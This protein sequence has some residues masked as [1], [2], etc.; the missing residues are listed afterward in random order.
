MFLYILG[1]KG[2]NFWGNKIA[3]GDKGDLSFFWDCW[4]YIIMSGFGKQPAKKAEKPIFWGGYMLSAKA[5][6]TKQYPPCQITE[7]KEQVK[8][9]ALI[10][11]LNRL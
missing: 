11:S 10:S 3:E 1:V 2:T 9:I 7:N 5:L 8:G 4:Y 6:T